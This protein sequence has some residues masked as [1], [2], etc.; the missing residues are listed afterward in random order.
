MWC[1]GVQLLCAM[2][3][4]LGKQQEPADLH[5]SDGHLG[6]GRWL[7]SEGEDVS[8]HREDI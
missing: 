2:G 8:S 4:A 5:N 6:S 7:G 1:C 3:S